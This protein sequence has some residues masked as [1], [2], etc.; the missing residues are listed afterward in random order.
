MTEEQVIKDF[1]KQTIET[2]QSK[3][4]SL[5]PRSRLSRLKHRTDNRASK[6]ARCSPTKMPN[7]IKRLYNIL[8]IILME[9]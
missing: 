3:Y 7:T 5:T 9:I 1:E 8:I 6:L 4:S 2:Q